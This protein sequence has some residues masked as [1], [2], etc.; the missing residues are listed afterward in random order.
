MN[1]GVSPSLHNQ[2]FVPIV[3]DLDFDQ[4]TVEL[5]RGLAR[6]FV[7]HVSGREGLSKI[8]EFSAL[9]LNT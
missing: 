4:D 2:A 6:H 3:M 7:K 1:R 5:Y 9:V 8:V